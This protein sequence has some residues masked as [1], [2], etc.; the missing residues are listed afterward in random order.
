MTGIR[1]SNLLVLVTS[2]VSSSSPRPFW[3]PSLRCCP[4]RESWKARPLLHPRYGGVYLAHERP[5]RVVIGHVLLRGHA[6]NAATDRAIV[7]AS[8]LN[9][10]QQQRTRCANF[11]LR[12]RHPRPLARS[13]STRRAS[14]VERQG[15]RQ[16]L[17]GLTSGRDP[18]RL[19]ETGIA[20]R[21][22]E[23][24]YLFRSPGT[25]YSGPSES[26]KQSVHRFR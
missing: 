6:R 16:R 7:T 9:E 25:C 2:L 26:V 8:A 23:S 3:R 19:S 20:I 14:C 10:Q 15:R 4:A 5:R 17:I 24:V 21:F 12:V 11:T 18:R 13:T 1:L 22:S